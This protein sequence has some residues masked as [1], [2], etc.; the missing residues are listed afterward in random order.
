MHLTSTSRRLAVGV[1][2]SGSLAK[3]YEIASI[4]RNDSTS[5]G[6]LVPLV[7]VREAIFPNMEAS[8]STV[9]MGTGLV[10]FGSL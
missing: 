7:A 4:F 6:L 3:L 5:F 9:L 2:L 10:L 1:M 8:R